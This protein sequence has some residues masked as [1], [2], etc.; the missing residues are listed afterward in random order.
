MPTLE[1]SITAHADQT[2]AIESFLCTQGALAITYLDAHDEP[3]L[4]PEPG[5]TPLWSTCKIKGL[6]EDSVNIPAIEQA[7]AMTFPNIT[8]ALS[9]RIVPDQ[10][11]ERAWLEDYQP[12]RIN[13][14]LIICPKGLTPPETTATVITLDPGLAFGTGTHPT[15]QHCL[16]ALTQC[17]LNNK[18]VL[19]YGCGSGILAISAIKLGACMAYAVDNEP[20]ALLATKYNQQQNHIS[21][22][23]IDTYLPDDMPDIAPVDVVVANILSNTIIALAPVLLHHLK[24]NGTLVLSGI[25]TS[26]VDDVLN[27]FKHAITF[28]TP[29]I[30]DTWVGLSGHKINN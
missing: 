8:E 30:S 16:A 13:D 25:L 26:Q 14:A 7:F 11:W 27:A 2:E 6:F 3:I 12:I 18:T 4:E 1:L 28:T 9:S 20:Q 5:T 17:K 22:A 21:A 23:C 19:D 15:T 29:S 24:P 10:A